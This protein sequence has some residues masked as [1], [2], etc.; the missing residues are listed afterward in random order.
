VTF[1]ATKML[2]N[3]AGKTVTLV[4][5]AHTSFDL[6]SSTSFFVDDVD[7]SAS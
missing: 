5:S 6:F 3:F 1:N 2:A 7:V 4:F